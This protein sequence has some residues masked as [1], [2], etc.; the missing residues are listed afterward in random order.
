MWY[1]GMSAT[2]VLGFFLAAALSRAGRDADER[3]ITALRE[4]LSATQRDLHSE[5]VAKME[6]VAAQ[7][8]AEEQLKAAFARKSE[9]G[10]RAWATRKANAA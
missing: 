8:Q 4:A 10:K 2:A 3:T 9:A 7:E 5:F 6:A 1:I